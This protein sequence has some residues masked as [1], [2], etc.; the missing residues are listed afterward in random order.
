MQNKYFI[1][2]NFK[3]SDKDGRF[4]EIK[5]SKNQKPSSGQRNAESVVATIPQ[6]G[7]GR[8]GLLVSPAPQ[9]PD[10]AVLVRAVDLCAG[11]TRERHIVDLELPGYFLN[12]RTLTRSPIP[13]GRMRGPA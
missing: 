10:V 12:V 9:S 3:Q 6:T 2:N 13:I 4:K 1:F 7:N 11:R 5:Q 8:A